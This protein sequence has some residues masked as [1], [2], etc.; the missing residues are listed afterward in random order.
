MI[1][2]S[3]KRVFKTI[4]QELTNGIV[5]IS[6][7]IFP[8]AKDNNIITKTYIEN[9]E[10]LLHHVLCSYLKQNRFPNISYSFYN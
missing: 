7:R 2:Y 6:Y 4:D 9:K 8:F 3:F 1:I 5:H 10:T